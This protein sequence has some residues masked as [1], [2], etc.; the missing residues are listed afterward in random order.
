[1]EP[2]TPSASAA[3]IPPISPEALRALID[4]AVEARVNERLAGIEKTLGELKA[5]SVQQ[6][7]DIPEDR[8]TLVVFSGEMD[9][10]MAAFNIAVGAASMGMQVS[11]FFTFWG[12]SA[13]RVKT[14]YAG[15]TVGEKMAALMLPGGP[16]SVP[17]SR[18]NMAGAGPLFF[19]YLMRQRNVESLPNLVDLARELG[20]RMVA[21]EMSL[22]VMGITRE[23]L[24]PGIDYGG[25]AT[26]L[27]DAAKSK[28]TLFI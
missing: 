15:K 8:A 21:C 9:N 25:V 3:P 20:V 7:A 26:Y 17:T 16:A 14:T 22:G 27:A 4:Q 23:E 28:V 18:M 11:M 1:M 13:L 24:V 12:L 2:A 5:L 10:L 6:K 19:K